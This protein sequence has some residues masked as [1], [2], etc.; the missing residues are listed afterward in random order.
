MNSWNFLSINHHKIQGSKLMPSNWSGSAKLSVCPVL[1]AVYI[2]WLNPH[3]DGVSPLS[4]ALSDGTVA[5]TLQF[6]DVSS[7]LPMN[8]GQNQALLTTKTFSTIRLGR[9]FELFLKI[10]FTYSNSTMGMS[11]NPPKTMNLVTPSFE[12]KIIQLKSAVGHVNN[13]V[14]D[15]QDD[16]QDHLRRKGSWTTPSDRLPVP[17]LVG[18]RTAIYPPSSSNWTIA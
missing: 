2:D 5:R 9:G 14:H 10:Q 16:E 15:T 17:R 7:L 8:A 13:R 4:V 12:P 6:W 11:P 1:S 18:T 3:V